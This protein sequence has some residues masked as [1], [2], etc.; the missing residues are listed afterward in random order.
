M[1]TLLLIPNCNLPLG[2]ALEVSMKL[3]GPRIAVI[4][5]LM[6]VMATTLPSVAVLGKQAGATSLADNRK[7][8]NIRRPA[9]AQSSASAAELNPQAIANIQ[10]VYGGSISG[11]ISN[12]TFSPGT[13]T[14]FGPEPVTVNIYSQNGANFL[15][16]AFSSSATGGPGP[17]VPIAG[18]INADG[19][20][21]GTFDFESGQ[22]SNTGTF[23]GRVIA[24]S[25]SFQLTGKE[26][27]PQAGTCDTTYSLEAK[28]T[29]PNTTSDVQISMLPIMAILA[30]G[31]RFTYTY[32]IKNAGP[33]LAV[34]T[35]FT[36]VVP[37]G[38]TIDT[39]TASQ[40]QV[41][42]PGP[43]KTGQIIVV[44]GSLEA[45]TSATVSV[46]VNILVAPGTSLVD[47]A[48]AASESIDPNPAN[49]ALTSSIPIM[50]GALVT[51]VWDQLVPTASDPT[52]APV[53]L[54]VV[55]VGGAGMQ[56]AA[57]YKPAYP[58]DSTPCTL[59]NV[60]I[61]KSDSPNVQP[62]PDNLWKTVPPG[63]VESTMAAAPGGSF[64]LLTNVWNCGGSIVES[65]SSNEAGVPPGPTITKIKAGAKLK[66]TGNGYSSTVMVF[67]DGIGFMKM[68]VFRTPTLIVQK[69]S[70]TTGVSISDYLTPGRTV[71]VTV[72]NSDGGMGTISITN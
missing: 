58:Q 14:N 11:T 35:V 46:T 66:I 29:T 41:Y 44:L 2:V 69:G 33:G 61:Y 48:D 71:L 36:E 45:G 64:Y 8:H 7:G 13:S 34:A 42:A 40:G 51:L 27:I 30:T 22:V 21:S 23:S 19:G 59:V 65:G 6:T 4:C 32:T 38:T 72:E 43:G 18:T 52:P 15:A 25:L 24:G 67:M 31:Q 63:D 70:L 1:R 55:P 17:P 9:S 53:N 37:D 50:G 28:L 47:S 60:N 62:I 20:V 26:T 54:R 57:G 10:G 16:V 49:N 56:T 39:V 12:C 3:M 5:S 68:P